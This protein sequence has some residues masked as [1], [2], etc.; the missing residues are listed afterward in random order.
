MAGPR[1]NRMQARKARIMKIAFVSIVATRC[2]MPYALLR[3]SVKGGEQ[4]V[5]FID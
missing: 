2:A 4:T 3:F 1:P 5:E